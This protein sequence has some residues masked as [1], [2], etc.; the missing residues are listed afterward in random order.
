MCRL[1]VLL[2]LF[3]LTRPSSLPS[4]TTEL[5]D[6]AATIVG[7]G[8]SPA[9][10]YLHFD[11][12]SILH[13]SYV[14]LADIARSR[15]VDA[16]TT[17]NFF[18]VTKTLTAT[19]ILQ[20]A[21]Q[22]LLALDTPVVRYLG[23]FPYGDRITL[24]HLLTHTGGLPN[25]L[26]L[27]WVHFPEEHGKFDE[28]AFFE[29]VFTKHPKTRSVPGASMRY[30]NLDYVWLGWVIE[31]VSG[32]PYE[33][34]V[35]E[36]LLSKSGVGAQAGFRIDP[37]VHAKGYQP[38]WSF[39]NLLLGMF[40]DKAKLMGPREGKWKPF[41]HNQLNGSAYGGL[42]GTPA[43]LARIGQMMLGDQLLSPESKRLFFEA[44]TLNDGRP[45]GMALS[46]FTGALHGHAYRH[47]AGG[48][49][50]YYAEFR[51]YPSLGR[52]SVLV[53]NSTGMT[54]R[55]LLDRIDADRIASLKAN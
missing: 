1:T 44:Y 33:A 30:S 3:M 31:R 27:S 26:P 35:Q 52:G 20:L 51:L 17:F 7:S 53:M 11:A 28:H 25:P 23:E 19:A 36:H 8:A 24:R 38:Y 45:A 55:K 49:G 13:R 2:I 4:P 15:A 46:W 43:A 10:V 21:E 47:H 29:K 37:A 42:I 40:I 14:G 16:G 5:Q 54:D 48:G 32:K 12:D 9:A 18:S 6:P 41:R 22:G 34:Y 50:G 39:M